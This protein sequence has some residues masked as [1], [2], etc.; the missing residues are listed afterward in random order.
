MSQSERLKRH[1]KSP[2]PALNVPRRDEALATDTVYSN[3]L[4]IFGGETITQFYVGLTT[5][6]CNAYGIKSEKQF[7]NTLKDIIRERGAPNKLVS[8]SAQVEIRK[9][10]KDILRTLV[11]EDWQSTP[12]E[13]QQNPAEQQYQTVVYLMN[14][15]MDCTVLHLSCGLRH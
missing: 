9:R 2:H 5:H 6:I 7:V 8:D 14:L 4:A 10:I 11:I 12:H 3:V 13:H 15:L 1:F